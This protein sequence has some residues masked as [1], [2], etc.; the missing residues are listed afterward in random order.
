MFNS[1][2]SVVIVTYD[3]NNQHIILQCMLYI[4]THRNSSEI[5]TSHVDTLTSTPVKYPSRQSVT[6]NTYA[7]KRIIVCVHNID[8][9]TAGTNLY[10]LYTTTYTERSALDFGY[11]TLR[12]TPSKHFKYL[13][14]NKNQ[15]IT[16][17][18][19]L[20]NVL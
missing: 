18:I 19:I 2:T 7:Y 3:D 4:I 9:S 11:N 6:L 13:I 17:F 12:P 14:N 20:Y 15:D 5:S 1:K 16:Y 10:H 8:T